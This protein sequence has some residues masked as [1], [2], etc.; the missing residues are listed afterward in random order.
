MAHKTFISY[1]YSEARYLRDDIIWALGADAQFYRGETSESP[2]LTDTTTENIKKKLSDMIFGTSVTIVILSP[3]MNESKW[4]PWEIKYSLRKTSRNSFTS[5]RNG[6]VGVIQKVDGG[7]DWFER[8]VQKLDGHI[9]TNYNT[10]LLCDIIN[11][12]RFN[13]EPMEYSCPICI[14]VNELYASYISFVGEDEFLRNYDKYIDIAF[15]KSQNDA[16][17]Y[18]VTVNGD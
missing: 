3:H 2:D 14:S 17:G 12:N 8:K 5:Q 1:K 10:D 15:N 7:Y 9:V 11:A 13:Q 4:I 18:R 16:R 6:L